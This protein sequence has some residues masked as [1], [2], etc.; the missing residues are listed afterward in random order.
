[1]YD[2]DGNKYSVEDG[3]LKIRTMSPSNSTEWDIVTDSKTNSEIGLC[4]VFPHGV[5]STMIPTTR[6]ECND[7]QDKV[8]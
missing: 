4:G 2:E 8:C 3:D 5:E 7:F 1:M 6:D